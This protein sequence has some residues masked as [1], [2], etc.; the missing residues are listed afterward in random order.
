MERGVDGLRVDALEV[1][2]EIEDTSQDEPRSDQDVPPVQFKKKKH[3]NNSV[4]KILF[5]L[6]YSHYS[7]GPEQNMDG[8]MVNIPCH[9]GLTV[10]KL[11]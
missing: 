11:Q 2:F 7:W 8:F 10:Q 9:A 6:L 1:L 5:N 4:L 3:Q